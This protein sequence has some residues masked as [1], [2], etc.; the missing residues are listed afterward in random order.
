MNTKS[1][2]SNFQGFGVYILLILAVVLIWYVMSGNSNSNT[3]TKAEFVKALQ[4]KE[5]VSVIVT[6]NREV[7][8]G[9]LRV[10]L[11]NGEKE[12]LYVTDVTEIQKVMDDNGFSSYT[13]S[14][15]PE[16][17][18]IMSLLPYLIIFGA[19]FILFMIMNNHAAA[20]NGGSKMMNFGKS[21]ARLASEDQSK[22]GFSNVAGLREEKD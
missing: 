4:E 18:W 1:K 12:I 13:V 22:V 10:T 11:S 3:Y 21:R 7:P 9:N 19:F 15:V 20:Q 8:T 6:Q 2:K 5:V 16:E 14:D 17:N